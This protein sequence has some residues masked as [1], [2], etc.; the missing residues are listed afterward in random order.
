[1]D[2]SSSTLKSIRSYRRGGL[3]LSLL[4]IL[5]FILSLIHVT[6][7]QHWKLHFFPAAISLAAVSFGP[8]G[9]L[10]AGM[11]G[12]LYAGLFMGNPYLIVGNA[13]LGFMT[14]YFFRK[15]SRMLPS[16]VFAFVCQLPWLIVSDYF[17][18]GLSAGFIARLVVVLFLGNL[19]W[20]LFIDLA[21]KPIKRFLC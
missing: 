5:P 15:I 2:H 18:M 19:L 1:M 16:V 3:A 7:A 4:V 21:M 12:S 11:A 17:F 14:G 6:F 13:I 8:V 10:I 20:A 9:G